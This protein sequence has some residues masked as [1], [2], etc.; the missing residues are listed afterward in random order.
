M[1]YAEPA[2]HSV[3]TGSTSSLGSFSGP[4]PDRMIDVGGSHA[5]VTPSNTARIVPVT[6]SGSAIRPSETKLVAQLRLLRRR[7][8]ATENLIGRVPRQHQGGSKDQHRHQHEQ[9]DRDRRP[10]QPVCDQRMTAPRDGRPESWRSR[11]RHP[12]RG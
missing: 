1:M 2:M 12:D 3:N 11:G 9:Q 6:N 7:P 5:S 4:E 8:A 10:P